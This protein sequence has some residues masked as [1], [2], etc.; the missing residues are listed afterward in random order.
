MRSFTLSKE[1]FKYTTLALE[2]AI[3]EGYDGVEQDSVVLQIAFY[4]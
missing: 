3:V 2:Y 1:I 4:L